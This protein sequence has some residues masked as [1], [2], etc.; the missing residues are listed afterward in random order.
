MTFIKINSTLYLTD[1]GAMTNPT[2]LPQMK[3]NT[4]KQRTNNF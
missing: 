3:V 4:T 1:S 2:I